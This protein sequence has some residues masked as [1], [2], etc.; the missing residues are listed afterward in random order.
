[1]SVLQSLSVEGCREGETLTLTK[2]MHVQ[3]FFGTERERKREKL[4][5]VFWLFNVF[6]RKFVVGENDEAIMMRVPATLSRFTVGG[7]AWPAK[8]CSVHVSTPANAIPSRAVSLIFFHTFH[9]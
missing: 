1:M 7:E 5:A 2:R 8:C 6:E 3:E 9:Q 4:P